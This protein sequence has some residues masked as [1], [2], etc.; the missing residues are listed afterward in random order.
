MK[1]KYCV[2][3]SPKICPLAARPR[4]PNRL[5][6]A[7][8]GHVHDVERRAGDLGQA[9]GA[10]GG[11]GLQLGRA[12]QRVVLRRQVAGGDRLLDQ[13]VDHVAVLGVHHDQQ[14]VLGGLL[15]GAEERGVVHLQHALV[16]HEQLQAGDA[17]LRR[18]A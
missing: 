2:Q 16:G 18:T 15:H 14:P 9:D 5:H 1:K 7:G 13:D 11:L 17:V 6:R 8:V 10:V 3:V 4:Q 12:G